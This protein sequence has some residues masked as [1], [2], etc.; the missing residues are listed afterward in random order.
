MTDDERRERRRQRDEELRRE[1]KRALAFIGVALIAVVIIGLAL[2]LVTEALGSN[3]APYPDSESGVVDP[4]A[5]ELQAARAK[6]AKLERRVRRQARRIRRQ[7]SDFRYALHASSVGNDWL[8]RAFLCVYRFERGADGWRTK[9]GNGY[10]GGLQMDR[11]FQRAHGARFLAA[12]GSA[13]RWP[14]SV[15]IAV[16]ID[17]WTT[18]RFEPWP[19]TARACGLR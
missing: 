19:N 4:L 2:R 6:N 13:D 12:F 5:V 14:R 15:Q 16:A 11:S 18:R 3:A 10:D 7:R 1:Q 8:E 17:G 9:T